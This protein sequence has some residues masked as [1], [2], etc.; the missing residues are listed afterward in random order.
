MPIRDHYREIVREVE[1]AT[2]FNYADNAGNHEIASD[3]TWEQVL[4]YTVRHVINFGGAKP[5]YR[6]DKYARSIKRVVEELKYVRRP[7]HN[8]LHVDIGC[9]PGLYHWALLDYFGNLSDDRNACKIFSV[10]YDHS[11]EMISL[12][13]RCADRI[14]EHTAS[15]CPES[16]EYFSNLNEMLDHI[17]SSNKFRPCDAFITFGHVLIQSSHDSHAIQNFSK[18]VKSLLPFSR[19][20]ILI[21]CDAKSKKH[22]SALASRWNDLVKATSVPPL[23]IVRVPKQPLNVIA[24]GEIAKPTPAEK[25]AWNSSEKSAS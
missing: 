10:G 6:Y 21:A 18:I 3:A 24:Y 25:E 14:Q 19:R 8:I 5:H 11:N 7:D 9:G 22:G 12:A 13:R 20:T 17:R 23:W 16:V 4:Q 2:G 15:S 1:R